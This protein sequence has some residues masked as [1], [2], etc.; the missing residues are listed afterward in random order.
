MTS[1]GDTSWLVDPTRP[2]GPATRDEE[3]PPVGLVVGHRPQT[4]LGEDPLL[5]AGLAV[6]DFRAVLWQQGESDVIADTSR[7]TY[8]KNIKTI[9]ETLARKFAEAFGFH[10]YYLCPNP[11]I[12]KARSPRHVVAQ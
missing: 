9:R 11:P 2:T 3:E 10:G 5:A 1:P 12:P 6:G 4:R 7:A 8:I